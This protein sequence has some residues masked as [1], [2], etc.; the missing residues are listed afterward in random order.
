[1]FDVI[2]DNTVESDADSALDETNINSAQQILNQGAGND[3][4]YTVSQK[5]FPPLNSVT[6]SN[7]NRFSQFL[8]C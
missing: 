3:A 5:K 1:M 4:I 6:L 8:H 7:L 2:I